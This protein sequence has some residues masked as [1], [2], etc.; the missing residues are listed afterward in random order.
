MPEREVMPAPEPPVGGHGHE[1]EAARG[2]RA[3]RHRQRRDIV[4]DVLD[5]VEQEHDLGP[6]RRHDQVVGERARTHVEAGGAR[7][8]E[9]ARVHLHADRL[10][11]VAERFE[12][13]AAAAPQ[14]EDPRATAGEP[15]AQAGAQ[16]GQAPPYQ[17]RRS[18]SRWTAV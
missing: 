18:S 13:V 9:E 3:T 12:H 4:V 16:D 15:G 8:R 11:E 10:A 1:Q 5:D 17:C 7:R 2:Q 6:A 14:L